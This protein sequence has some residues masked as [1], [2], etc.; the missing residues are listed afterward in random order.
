MMPFAELAAE[1]ITSGPCRDITRQIIG[2]VLEK[3]RVEP[4]ELFGY[5]REGHLVAARREAARRL[6]KQGY[7]ITR[8]GRILHRDHSTI[9]NYIYESIR[10]AK[11][12]RYV[13][14]RGCMV[15]INPQYLEGLR[16]L[17]AL[18]E[19]TIKAIVNQAISDTLEAA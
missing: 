18:S 2:A 10:K 1:T 6:K 11:R 14:K 12:E 9:S 4:V 3:Y 8:I 16:R 5:S 7:S 17:A 19:T 15:E 13:G